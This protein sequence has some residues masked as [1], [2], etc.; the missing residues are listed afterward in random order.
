VPPPL[1]SHQS[2]SGTMPRQVCHMIVNEPF[3]GTS[4]YRPRAWTTIPMLT[5]RLN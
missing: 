4:D 3:S 5:A 1:V 2:Q